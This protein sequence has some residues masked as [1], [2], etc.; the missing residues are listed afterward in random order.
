VRHLRNAMVSVKI[1]GYNGLLKVC[2]M[3]DPVCDLIIGNDW[4]RPVQKV[5][6]MEVNYLIDSG[7]LMLENTKYQ[8]PLEYCDSINHRVQ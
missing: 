8:E 6:E 2:N 7:T 3:K 1:P 4:K 5:D